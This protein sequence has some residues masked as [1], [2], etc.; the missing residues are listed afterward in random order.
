MSHETP[1]DT[2]S[3]DNPQALWS[4]LLG[5][6]SLVLTGLCGYGLVI[7][8]PA[9]YLGWRAKDR[10]TGRGLA[11]AGIVT[12]GLAI[13]LGILWLVLLVFGAVPRPAEG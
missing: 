5:I 4:V 2:T 6:L 3:G 11:I 9:V 12:G 8:F 7:G 10:P 13:V 1:P